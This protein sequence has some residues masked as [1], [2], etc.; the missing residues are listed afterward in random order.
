ME[1]PCPR[2]FP[3][4]LTRKAKS[5][6]I[7]AWPT[8]DELPKYLL[9]KMQVVPMHS[10]ILPSYPHMGIREDHINM[11]KFGSVEHPG[12]IGIVGE[13][14]RWIKELE[15]K[16]VTL[17]SSILS[18]LS[19]HGKMTVDLPPYDFDFVDRVILQTQIQ[20]HLAWNIGG[21]QRLGLYGLGGSG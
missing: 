11:T 17:T 5:F 15:P 18:S 6:Y 8:V 10:A 21:H 13:I 16:S 12:F 4:I 19:K 2:P 14:R 3:Y 9:L 20:D 7:H 1:S